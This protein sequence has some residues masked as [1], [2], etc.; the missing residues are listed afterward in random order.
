MSEASMTRTTSEAAPAYLRP[1]PPPSAARRLLHRY[2]W[3]LALVLEIIVIVAVLE[4]LITGLAIW[5]PRFFPPPSA[6]A[7]DFSRLVTESDLQRHIT[8][9]LGNFAV[10]YLLAAAIAVPLGLLMGTI[11]RLRQLAGPIVWIFY[12]TPRIALAPLLILWL[13]YGG[14]SKVAVIFLMAVFPI[15]ISVWTGAES[16]DRTLLRAGTVFGA[17]RLD[18]YRKVTLPSILPYVLTGLKLGVARALIG[19]VI[20]E[21]LGSTAGIGYLIEILSSEFQLAGA[22]ALTLVLMVTANVSMALLDLAQRRLAP[23]YREVPA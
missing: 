11:F 6:I 14:A 4:I 10:G 21:F 13:G 1:I 3:N 9:S 15:L 12:S 23:W 20:A 2:G 17:G 16:V 18:L 22:L 7:A 5:N 19:V 8:F